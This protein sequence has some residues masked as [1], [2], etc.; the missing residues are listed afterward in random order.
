MFLLVTDEALIMFG[1]RCQEKEREKRKKSHFGLCPK[2]LSPWWCSWGVWETT[3]Y[4]PIELRLFVS[5][6]D[7]PG[8]M[9]V[10]LYKNHRALAH[11]KVIVPVDSAYKACVLSAMEQQQQQSYCY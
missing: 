1:S 10:K 2:I 8:F 5:V 4:P 11:I 6:T 3:S 7:A 9:S